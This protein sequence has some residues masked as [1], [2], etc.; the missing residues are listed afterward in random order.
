MV[1]LPF[2]RNPIHLLGSYMTN[3]AFNLQRLLPFMQRCGDLMARES[4]MTNA[5]HRRKTAE[6]A[7]VLGSALEEVARASGSVAHIYKNLE[8]GPQTGQVRLDTQSYDRMFEEIIRATGSVR[9]NGEQAPARAPP[10]QQTQSQPARVSVPA[11]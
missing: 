1:Q 9:V 8:L 10:A 7:I 4:L 3:M 2:D 5:E 6:L 11:P